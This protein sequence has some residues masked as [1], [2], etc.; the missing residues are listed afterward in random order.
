MNIDK[1]EIEFFEKLA[2][3][4]WDKNGEFKPLH[5]INDLRLSFINKNIK[6]NFG[7]I[8]GLKLLDIGCGGG[9][10]SEEMAK[11]GCIVTGI[12]AGKNNIKVAKLHAQQSGLDI[13]YLCCDMSGLDKTKF[14][15]ILNMEV[16]EHVPNPNLFIKESCE[17]LDK[18]GCMFI[19]TINRTIKSLLFAK[20]GAEYVLRWLP[21]GTHKWSKFIK[22]S[23]LEVMLNEN[24]LK[25]SNI[26]GINFNPLKWQWYLSIR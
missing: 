18:N 19:S 24:G 20:I 9:L 5:Q 11:L 7:K 3:K 25:T 14:D 26:K 12:D 1:T 22:P 21:I 10:L 6:N 16:I 8:E 2:D 17:F 13:N 15:I 23:E 4:W